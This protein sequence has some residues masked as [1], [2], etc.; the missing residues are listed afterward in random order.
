M[1]L[2]CY[3]QE[4]IAEAV[5][6]DQDTV[7]AETGL[8]RNPASLPKSVQL[9]ATY[10]DADWTPPLWQ[11]AQLREQ[12]RDTIRAMWL[13]SYTDEE[14][15]LAV[16]RSDE[17]VREKT[18]VVS[19]LLEELPKVGEMAAIYADSEW[20]PPLYNVRH[21]AGRHGRRAGVVGGMI[22]LEGRTRHR[23]RLAGS[24]SLATDWQRNSR[25]CRDA[26]HT[27]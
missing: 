10:A 2:A 3:T 21:A 5:G 27:W 15:A 18:T 9:L 1:W 8:L 11:P 4:E 19:Q 24:V 20:T 26:V 16:G 14:I 25:D 12:R 6:V 13:A 22:G 23:W 7:S 17:W